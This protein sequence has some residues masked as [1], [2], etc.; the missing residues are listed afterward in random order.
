MKKVSITKQKTVFNEEELN[1]GDFILLGFKDMDKPKKLVM[2][3]STRDENVIVIDVKE[4]SK[5]VLNV[6]SVE[7]G[8]YFIYKPKK[9]TFKIEDE[10]QDCV[11]TDNKSEIMKSIF[12]TYCYDKDIEAILGAINH[13]LKTKTSSVDRGYYEK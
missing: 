5:H 11:D 2:V 13:Q 7:S 4:K 12:S 1:V 9:I 10:D 6:K 3:L 8:A